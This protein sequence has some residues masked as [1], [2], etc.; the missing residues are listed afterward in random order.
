MPKLVALAGVSALALVLMLQILPASAQRGSGNASAGA[1]PRQQAPAAGRP[2]TSRV[3]ALFPA[4]G[5]SA[6]T[7]DSMKERTL[8]GMPF[9]ADQTRRVAPREPSRGRGASVGTAVFVGGGPD[10][11]VCTLLLPADADGP[12]GTCVKA[13]EVT[14]G[15]SVV[16]MERA[17]GWDVAGLAPP[18]TNEVHLTLGDG[19]TT[20][21]P[22]DGGAF[23]VWVPSQ[24]EKVAF[25]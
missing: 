20:V 12:G 5:R 1:D 10:D 8:G 4:L 13:D 22:A 11:T 17:G 15:Q 16:R 18:D 24:P 6:G 3:A 25:K 7:T 2:V 21:A 23:S 19:A 14:A 9:Y